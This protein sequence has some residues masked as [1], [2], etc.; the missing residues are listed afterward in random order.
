MD[1][2]SL[3]KNKIESFLTK[4]YLNRLIKG[5]IVFLVISLSLV[6]FFTLTEYYAYMSVKAKTFAIFA[7]TVLI[8]APA[9]YYIFIPLS[10]LLRISRTISLHEAAREISSKVPELKDRLI[11]VVELDDAARKEEDVELLSAAISQKSAEINHLDFK[12]A[13]NF[14][15]NYKYLRFLLIILLV[16]AAV[17]ISNPAAFTE[18]GYRIINYNKHFEKP[19]QVKFEILNNNFTV[20]RGNDFELRAQSVGKLR[21]SEVYVNYGDKKLRMKQNPQNRD[22]YV[23]V[24]KGLNNSLNFRITAGDFISRSNEIQVLSPPV[25][26]KF[27]LTA[28][29]PKY[30]GE[31]DTIYRNIGDVNVPEGSRLVWKF[32]TFSTDTLFFISDGSESPTEFKEGKFQFSKRILKDYNYTLKTKNKNFSSEHS[33]D[34]T[35]NVIPDLYPQISA[36][37]RVDSTLLSN[38]YFR[39]YIQDDYGV[40]SLQFKYRIL[41]LPH[42][43]PAADYESINIPADKISARQEFFYS[44]DFSQVKL[45]DNQIAEYFF[46]VRDNDAV[47]GNKPARSQIFYYSS[48]GFEEQ[49]ERP[50]NINESAQK[51]VESAREKA[52]EIRDALKKYRKS[53][54]E[55]SSENWEKKQFV[56]DL[57]K[58]KD[59]LQLL[60][61]QAKKDLEKARETADHQKEDEALRK[62]LEELQ[63]LT[64]ELI[65]DDIK[66]LMEEIERL[67]RQFDKK[68]L[69]E[70][71]KNKAENIDDFD[72]MLERNLELLKRYKVEQNVN[73]IAREME[74][75]SEEAEALSEK[76]QN[77]EQASDEIRKQSEQLKEKFEKLKEKYDEVRREN[78]NLEKPYP[79]KDFNKASEKIRQEFQN[80]QEMLQRNKRKK[81]SESLQKNSDN[82]KEMSES[83]QQ[84]MQSSSMTMSRENAEYLK[85]LTQD[86]LQLSFDQEALYKEVQNVSINDPKFS[87]FG[88]KQIQLQ[89]EYSI[90][91]DSLYSLSK[92]MFNLG[93]V[94]D[95]ETSDIENNLDF[96]LNNFREKKSRNVITGQVKIMQSFNNLV[97]VLSEMIDRMENMQAGGSGGEGDPNN[98]QPAFDGLQQQQENLRKQLEDMLEKMKEGQQPGGEPS[99]KEIAEILAKQEIFRQKLE[100]MKSK[101]DLGQETKKLLDEISK[102]TEENEVKLMNKNIEPDLLERQKLIK[103]R[104]L[105]AEEAENT[106]KTDPERESE[107]ATKKAYKSPEDVFE[108]AEDKTGIKET[109]NR[110]AVKLNPFYR[111]VFENYTNNIQEK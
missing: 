80:T 92:R 110:N 67:S 28:S 52:R 104:L 61:E 19:T 100:E 54:L 20:K 16:F 37:Q 83:M 59:E 99:A 40:S 103:T 57:N 74:N 70:L 10:K 13:V 69:E 1:S 38:Y 77:P 65:T 14:K 73:Q 9:V 105:E 102:L 95:K 63:K 106:R 87:D 51:S 101:Y 36:E 23:Y 94:I 49:L 27:T 88:E 5:I 98:P 46:E 35:V 56:Q 109:L 21:P 66:K 25:I 84:M 82:M 8:A 3:I 29:P 15:V 4:F 86:L 91:A 78:R 39:G 75:L 53:S 71:M 64:D 31:R 62:K 111:K 58:K 43:R 18:G 47:N 107:T 76:S 2:I 17:M 42:N 30:T 108:N 96:V 68:K 12:K 7:L 90:V 93:N 97:L 55:N 81:S 11:N 72:K 33:V 24:F 89:N 44:F 48:P 6:L 32:N 26:K 22:E 34:Y 60:I 45:N 50:S 41:N 85:K 79:L